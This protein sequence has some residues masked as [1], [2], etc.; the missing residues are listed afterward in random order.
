MRILLADHTRKKL[1]TTR[2]NTFKTMAA[3]DSYKNRN[4]IAGNITSDIFINII[5]SDAETTFIY[6]V[7]GERSM[8][9]PRKD[10]FTTIH[11]TETIGIIFLNELRIN[12]YRGI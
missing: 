8:N 10:M 2:T 3:R 5:K 4:S 9:G 12:Y 7:I 1:I 11:E 6:K